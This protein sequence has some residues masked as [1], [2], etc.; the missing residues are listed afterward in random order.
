MKRLL[1][2]FLAVALLALPA[3][4]SAMGATG[5]SVSPAREF[6]P[7]QVL[8]KFSGQRLGRAVQ[9]PQ[10]VGVRQ[11]TAALRASPD[12]AYAAPNYIATAS[13]F[14]PNDTG[15]ASS[16]ETS[17]TE[18]LIGWT[19]KQWNFLPWEG[20]ST[21][22]LPTSAG[23]IDALGAWQHL[24]EAGH[25][26]AS[27]ITIAVLDTGI[28]Y[29]PLGKRTHGKGA[30]IRPSPDFLPKQF[31]PGASFIN[32]DS[33]PVDANGH[34][35]HVA[36]TIAEATN[37]GFGLTGLAYGAKL[38]PVQVLN[39]A[40][41]GQALKIAKGIR[42][43]VDHGAQVINM[44]F[45]F[46][47]GKEVPEVDSALRYAYARGVVAVAAVGNLGSE[48]CVSPPSTGPH[49]IGVGGTTQ[50]GCLG[51][52]S[53]A[54]VDVDLVAPG[55]GTPLGGC[56]SVSAGPIYQVT[57]KPKSTT[58]FGIPSYYIGTSMAAAHVSGVA[59]MVLAGNVIPGKLRG[60]NLVQQVAQR[61]ALTA[62]PLGLS[63]LQEGAGLIDA[64][65]ATDPACQT[66]CLLR[67][68]TP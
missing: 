2:I 12:V 26:G 30:R 24:I 49:V 58:Q 11:A 40:G 7:R 21:P 9:L 38:M 3:G 4:G 62:R 29:R 68:K 14:F 65:L 1:P 5:P 19:A 60:K 52:Y 55:G 23:G 67:P 37:N 10:G 39:S 54:G 35:T 20:I 66:E 31:V 46:G 15:T 57:F 16:G 33:P 32:P 36:G 43:A 13:E 63:R 22:E 8:V 45:N 17:T 50:G 6:V 44:S 56:A 64:A 25:P 41:R 42:F 51:D 48:T 59:A 53:L 34:G 18:G 47:C 27:G 28:A 61:L